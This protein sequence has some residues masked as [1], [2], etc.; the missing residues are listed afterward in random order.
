MSGPKL[1]QAELE[2]I[3]AEQLERE[4]LAALK[5][6]QEAQSAYR[7]ECERANRLKADVSLLAGQADAVY[8]SDA[9]V[10]IKAAIDKIRI[11]PVADVKDP[12][13][14][15][16][17]KNELARAVQ[18]VSDEINKI[19]GA[20]AK[21]T[22]NDKELN[23]ANSVYQS[24][25]SAFS[26][27]GKEISVVKIDF[28]NSYDKDNVKKQLHA[29]LTH[30][31]VMKNRADDPYLCRFSEKAVF[32]IKGMLS[33]IDSLQELDTARTAMQQI[34]NEELEVIR[35]WNE[36]RSLY[37]E[38]FALASMTDRIPRSPRDFQNTEAIKNEILR[39]RYLYRKQDEMDYIA[40]QINDAMA[41][42]G[43]TFVTSRVLTKKDQ[44]ETDFSL[45]KAD[46]ET[47]I[48]VYTDQTGAVMM[49]MT[50]LSDNS[51][52]TEDDRD[53]SYQR[54]IDFCAGHSD[55]VAALAERGVFL[56]QKSYLE[57]DRA[58]TYKIDMRSQK[59]AADLGMV[60]K[61]AG[62]RK[63]DRRRRRRAGS[64]KVRAM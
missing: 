60:K 22:V 50:V 41:A 24:F 54:Q 7:E 61:D 10:Q 29:M 21:R 44:G 47:G 42:L 11:N 62:V 26:V 49:R 64:K 27:I 56:K 14:Y 58:H 5:K 48:A 31:Q 53:F 13:S 55:L 1:S 34:V 9:E 43:Y 39:L 63:T 46:E 20:A 8:R 35:L 23:D 36:R 52:I 6:L 18:A 57:P 37:H 4:R 33:G 59:T 45:Y 40:D 28:K 16:S 2:R 15:Y 32:K 3:R 38:Y 25:T 12:E 17:A 19:L 30:F 51:V